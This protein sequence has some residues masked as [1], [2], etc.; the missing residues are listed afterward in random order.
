MV[1]WNEPEMEENVPAITGYKIE[2]KINSESYITITENTASISTSF[3]HQG[4]EPNERYSYRSL[5]N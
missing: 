3:I 4:L 1:S 5:F 2:Y